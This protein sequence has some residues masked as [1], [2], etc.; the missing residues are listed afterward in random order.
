MLWR[1]IRFREILVGALIIFILVDAVIF[2]AWY[3]S[4]QGNRFEQPAM[5]PMAPPMIYLPLIQ[6]RIGSPNVIIPTQ[7]PEPEMLIHIVQSGDT[8]YD[9]AEKYGVSVEDIVKANELENP[10]WL[11]IGQELIIPSP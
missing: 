4:E 8:L 5:I 10:D 11:S 6:Q 9:I 1:G 2:L 3:R 7:S